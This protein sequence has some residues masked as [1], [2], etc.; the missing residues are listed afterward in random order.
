MASL[1]ACVSTNGPYSG[2]I[3]FTWTFTGLTCS[4]VPQVASV[5]I[6]IPGEVLQNNGVYPCLTNNY[7]GIVLHDFLPGDYSFTIQGLDARG[8]PLYAASGTFHIDGS[9]LVTVDLQPTGSYAYLTWTFPPLSGIPNPSCAQARINVVDVTIDQGSPT[10]YACADGQTQPGVVSVPMSIGTH[11][12]TLAASSA[13]VNYGYP[14]YTLVSTVTT[15]GTTPVAATYPLRWAV[16]GVA[17]QWDIS[18]GSCATIPTIYVNF[19]DSSGNLLYGPS[20]N[21]QACLGGLAPSGVILYDYLPPG[22]YVLTLQGS[23]GGFV[24]TNTPYPPVT[25]TAGFF[26]DSQTVRSTL[27]Y[28]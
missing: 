5:A 22:S 11:T 19:L 21:A 8:N 1:S 4:Q 17:V 2:D 6:N 14:Y 16:G 20:G 15:T 26:S 27:H 18:G 12:I 13:D 24:Y 9:I 25:I 28:P 23:Y 3:Q 10:R 7:P